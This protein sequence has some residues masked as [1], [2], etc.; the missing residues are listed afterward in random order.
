MRLYIPNSA[1]C[2]CWGLRYGAELAVTLPWLQALIAMDTADGTMRIKVSLNLNLAGSFQLCLQMNY[3]GR[4]AL[5]LIIRRSLLIWMWL[6]PGVQLEPGWAPFTVNYIRD[7]IALRHCSGC[8]FYRAEG[9]GSGW[10][11]AGN[12]VSS[13]RG[14]LSTSVLQTCMTDRLVGAERQG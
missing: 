3:K 12:R 4:C 10:D 6:L 7:V 13:V 11:A 9:L 14:H 5:G 8:Q 2:M 1:A